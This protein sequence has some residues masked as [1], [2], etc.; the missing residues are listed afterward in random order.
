M[1]VLLLIK[2]S[3]NKSIDDRL[4][5]MIGY[6]HIV[7]VLNLYVKKNCMCSTGKLQ[8][9]KPLKVGGLS[10]SF[11]SMKTALIVVQ[12]LR[13]FV[14]YTFIFL[15]EYRGLRIKILISGAPK[16]EKPLAY[17]ISLHNIVAVRQPLKNLKRF[18]VV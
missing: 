6:C 8:E 12:I 18:G 7:E 17:F 3:N 1:L 10:R 15:A 14:R 13:I 2:L 5:T 11:F 4:G 9:E 16:S